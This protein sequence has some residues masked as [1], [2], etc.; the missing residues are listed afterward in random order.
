MCAENKKIPNFYISLFK[1]KCPNCRK[2]NM[3]SSKSIFPLSKMMDMPERCLSCGL[4]FE[5]EVGFWY[6]TGYTS[7]GLSVAFIFALAVAFQVLYGFDWRD[8]SVFIFLGLM[9]TS[10]VLIQPLMMR[11][12]RALYLSF[13]IKYGEGQTMK[14]E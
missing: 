13:F 6:G 4:K 3:F 5:I 10:L 7:Y 8:N 14:S 1:L 11:F 9:V 12:S 2:G